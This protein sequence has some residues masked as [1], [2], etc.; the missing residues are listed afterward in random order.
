M[1]R[2]FK[3][4]LALLLAVPALWVC[5]AVLGELQEPGSVL[6]A[7]PGEALVLHLGEWALRVTLIALLTSSISRRTR[8]TQIVRSRRMVGLFAFFYAS[9]HFLAYIGFLA[10]FSWSEIVED[11]TDRTYITIGFSAWII[12][13][14]L[15]ATSTSGWQRRLRSTW[16]KLHRLVYPAVAL[17]LLHFWWLTKDGYGELI[18]TTIVF[19]LLLIERLPIFAPSRRVGK[20]NT[21]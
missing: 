7:D 6:G 19:V 8:F 3:P 9:A 21:I 13:F 5:Y 4:V 20:L 12:L 10:T 14:A 11:L 15:A 16:K 1:N 2:F 17:A 18:M